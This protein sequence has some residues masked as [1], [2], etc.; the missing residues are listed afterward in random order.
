M[1][2]HRDGF[3]II[4]NAVS[5]D[6]N[7]LTEIQQQSQKYGR[8]IFNDNENNSGNDY[9]RRQSKIKKNNKTE[10]L[11]NRFYTTLKNRFKKLSIGDTVIL[12]SLP[13][14]REQGKH[15]DFIPNDVF[16][17]GP[18]DQVP[19]AAILALEQDTTISVWPKSIRIASRKDN[20]NKRKRLIRKKAKKMNPGDIFVFRGDLV[21]AGSA[22]EKS[23]IRLHC[24]L[25]SP[26]VFREQNRT[27]RVEKDPKLANIIE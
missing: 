27:W 8:S 11:L 2:L 17:N 16:A 15:M 13:G 21:H 4:E 24:F 5:F 9:K 23:N 20:Q 25:D 12:R 6:D 10:S 3:T 26:S 7:E 18:D 1:S 14:C 19:L 22:Y